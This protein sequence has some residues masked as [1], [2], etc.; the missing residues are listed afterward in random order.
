MTRGKPSGGEPSW[1]SPA[2]GASG[3]GTAEAGGASR[4]LEGSASGRVSALSTG[5]EPGWAGLEGLGLGGGEL[6]RGLGR[7][8]EGSALGGERG[9]CRGCLGELC[10]PGGL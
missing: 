7:L 4:L 1:P 6:G 8:N 9:R 2:C 5:V 3:V 10:R